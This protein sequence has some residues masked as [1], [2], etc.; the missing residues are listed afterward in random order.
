MA[1]EGKPTIEELKSLCNYENGIYISKS[2]DQYINSL[3]RVFSLVNRNDKPFT[4]E[5]IKR[6]PELKDFLFAGVVD[7]RF[8]CNLEATPM[9]IN[10][11]NKRKNEKIHPNNFVGPEEQSIFDSALGVSY[12]ITCVLEGKNILLKLVVLERLLKIDCNPIIVDVFIIGE[13]HLLQILKYFNQWLL[14]E[15][16]LSYIYMTVAMIYMLLIGEE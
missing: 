5:D 8:I 14:L 2:G 16:Y 13:Q 11:S 1:K 6:Q 9:T 3:G 15:L 10:A 7:Y 12:L 4:I